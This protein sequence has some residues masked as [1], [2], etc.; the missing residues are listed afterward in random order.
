M[1]T[2]ALASIFT[3]FDY[4]TRFALRLVKDINRTRFL[5]LYWGKFLPKLNNLKDLRKYF[6]TAG[7]EK[8][9][10]KEYNDLKCCRTFKTVLKGK[11]SNKQILLLK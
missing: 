6:L 11:V 4:Y 3:L 5:F 1:H 10:K 9:I 8:A 7:F 2:V